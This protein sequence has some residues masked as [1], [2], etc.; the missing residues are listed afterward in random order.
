MSFDD[1][2]DV[3]G[4]PHQAPAAE[5]VVLSPYDGSE[6]GRLPRP[7]AADVEA[8][9]ARVAGA[10]PKTRRMPTFRRVEI[11][12]TIAETILRRKDELAVVIA[13]EAGKPLRAARVEAERA[14]ATFFAA[15]SEAE[16]RAGD[17]LPLDVN[18]ASLGRIGLVRRF[19]IG[20]V[21]AITPFNFPL[22]LTAHKVAPALAVGAPVVQK[23]ASQTPFSALVMQ[24]IV[25]D[26]GWP[27]EAYAVLPLGGAEAEPLVTDPRLPVV[28]FTGSGAV[29]WRLKSLV[30]KK[31]VALELGG[32]A[33]V[34][35]HSDADL[36][37]AVNRAVS[38][39][40]GYAGQ[41]CISLQRTLV[42]RPAFVAFRDRML[43]KVSHLVV[44]DPLHEATEVGP[45]I[46][47]AEAERALTWIEE[48]L[49]HGAQLLCGGRANGPLLEP[50]VLTETRRSMKVE[51]AE[52]FAPVVT[53]TAYDDF[54]EA[55]ARVN[56][57]P[58]G[59]QAG[60]FTRDLGRILR[61]HDALEVGAILINDVPTWRAD[62]MPYGGVKDSGSGREGPAYAM[63]ELTEPRLLVL[64]P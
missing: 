52:V 16:R 23:P 8:A 19:P 32:N 9:V 18:S 40:F 15:A 59:L 45:M 4:S 11:L 27:P 38:G 2:A 54:E 63:D 49:A 24:E 26:A 61:A 1:T 42:H 20:P 28:S 34:I 7:T 64:R 60:V 12:R 51:C 6:V 39:A 25:R 44:G 53:L 17:V 50:T 14:S 21:L 46:S 55:L 29:G 36:D 30:P 33:A 5:L 58:Y 56:D 10:F 31:R 22:N 43:E 62:R 47:V 41:S 37:D 57:S 3:Y 35:V 48:A 13:R